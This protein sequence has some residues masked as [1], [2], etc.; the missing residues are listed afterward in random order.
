MK[1]NKKKSAFVKLQKTRGAR[2]KTGSSFRDYPIKRAYKYLGVVIDERLNFKDHCQQ[3]EKKVEKS[4]RLIKIMSLNKMDAWRIMYAWATYV[5]P[6]FR[7]GALIFRKD[8]LNAEVKNAAHVHR[9][10]YYRSVKKSLQLSDKTSNATLR[11]FLGT[12]DHSNIVD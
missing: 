8:S 3:V 7:Y 2:T 4:L 10:L 5:V 6:H 11:N 12:W 9:R 1:I